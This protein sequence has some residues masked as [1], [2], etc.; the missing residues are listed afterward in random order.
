[1][2]L[3]ITAYSHLAPV[4]NHTDGWCNEEDGHGDLLHI[5]A[6]AYDCFPA[7]FAG[8]PV[9]G[10]RT[11][12]GAAFLEGGCFARTDKTQEHDFRAGSYSGYNA[13]R[14][15]LASQFNLSTDDDGMPD[16]ALPFYEL[17]WFADNEGCIG[18]EA[19][20]HLLDDFRVHKGVYVPTG[21]ERDVGRPTTKYD[22]WMRAFELAADGGLVRFH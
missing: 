8:I 17:I 1:M 12:G 21:W 7:S 18:P 11:S 2:G 3:D 10:K 15:H 14:T 13:W 16:P 9:L 19:A 20:F 4:G 22:E 5:Q 6:F